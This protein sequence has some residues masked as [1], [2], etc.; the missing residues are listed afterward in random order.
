MNN[1]FEYGSKAASS[2]TVSDTSSS[3]QRPRR[4]A[5]PPNKRLYQSTDEKI[6]EYQ[7]RQALKTLDDE[8]HPRNET[9]AAALFESEMK[10]M[11]KIKRQFVKELKALIDHEIQAERARRQ[12]LEKVERHR[13]KVELLEQE[14]KQL[15]AGL[16]RN[17]SLQA[18]ATVAAVPIATNLE[19]SEA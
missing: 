9:L 3:Y 16:S 17:P 18:L 10:E 2:I 1:S 5:A 7:A 12:R 11:K 13:K 8:E 14:K 15:G 19:P 6:R 4:Q